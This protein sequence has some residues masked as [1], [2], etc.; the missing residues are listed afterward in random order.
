MA[1]S[2]ER[3]RT[4]SKYV[5]YALQLY[6][7]GLSLRKASQRLSQFIKRNHVSIWNWIQRYKPRKI[8]QTRCKLSEFIIDETLIKVGS[9]YVWL[10]VA[11]EPTNRTILGIRISIERNMLVAERFIQSLIRRYGRHNISTDGGTWYPQACRFLNVKRHNHSSIEKS[12]IE[13]MIQYVKDRTEGFDDY[14]PCRR[15]NDCKLKHVMN[16]L[17]LFVDMHNRKIIGKSVK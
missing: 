10:W 12:F 5:Y 14:F 13:R 1:I 2:R 16:W 3:R 15:D 17:N 7:S 6:F 11:I 8:L 4:S 9:N